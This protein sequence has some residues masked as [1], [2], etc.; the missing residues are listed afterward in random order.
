MPAS[1]AITIDLSFYFNNTGIAPG[2]RPAEG[3]L[4]GMGAAFRAEDLQP[5]GGITAFQGTPFLFPG[6]SG[7]GMDN[8]ACEGQEVPLPA[9]VFEALHVLGMC[10]WRA[11]EERLRLQAPDGGCEERSLGLS[12]APRYRGLQYGEEEAVVCDLVIPDSVIPHI[13][14]LG[15]PPPSEDYKMTATYLEA[16]IWHQ[17]I[18]LEEPRPLAKFVLPDN[19]SMHLFALTMI[20]APIAP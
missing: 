9:G 17:V 1:R 19:P 3:G 6:R 16:G 8:I 2:G 15:R 12:D 4:D 13:V 11:F 20:A 7:R 18:L 14:L 10:D 5:P